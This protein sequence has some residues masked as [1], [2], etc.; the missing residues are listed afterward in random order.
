MWIRPRFSEFVM[1][2]I[3]FTKNPKVAKKRKT[4]DVAPEISYLRFKVFSS[5]TVSFFLPFLRREANTLRPLAD[6]ILS[7][8]PCLFF[9]FLFEG[10]NVRFMIINVY[11]KIKGCKDDQDFHD[12]KHDWQDFVRRTAG[13]GINQDVLRQK[14]PLNNPSRRFFS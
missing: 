13:F 3:N 10:W 5:E 7:R 4:G 1:C 8:N 11:P 14:I 12:F 2:L 6:A 9:L